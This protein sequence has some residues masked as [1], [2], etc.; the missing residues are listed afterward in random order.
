M[1]SPASPNFSPPTA[2]RW[3]RGVTLVLL[4]TV[5]LSL[6]NVFARIAQSP[7]AVPMFG[8]LFELGGYV[9]NDANKL[10]I[11]LLV[12][13]LRISFVLPVLWLML[14]IL[15]PGAWEE[16]R[17][18]VRGTDHKLQLRIGAAG[19]FLFLSQTS[20]YFS[21][22][23]VGPATAVTLF[24]IYPTVTTLL[25]WWLFHERPSY[26]HWLAVLLIYLGC[27]WLTVAPVFSGTVAVPI[28]HPSLSPTAGGITIGVIAALVSGV[29]F[30]LEGVIAQSCFSRVN[31][32]TFTGLIF[33]VEWV[34]LAIVHCFS[35]VLFLKEVPITLGL[36][37]I[38]G[39]ISITTLSGYL[40]NNFGI[41][42]IGAAATAMIG[43]SGPVM[44][45][46]LVVLLIAKPLP[47]DVITP[48]KWGAILLVSLGVL[49][50]NLGRVG[51]KSS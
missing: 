1:T 22:S 47:T 9:A 25:A 51:A 3:W 21:I 48:E 16:A 35:R 14:P 30:A 31:P 32:A 41:R 40:L 44:T 46:I 10:Q 34:L 20:I 45:A 27:I 38:G 2:V 4:T 12:L 8:G 7:R 23:N 50:M 37:G 36:I 49:L 13:F 39:L 28:L 17:Q 5:C 18:I 33:A 42:E 24:F 43:S 11:S 26:K 29:V 19:F 6:Q 15:K